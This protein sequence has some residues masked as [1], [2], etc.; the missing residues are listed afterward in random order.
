[1]PTIATRDAAGQ[2]LHVRED[3]VFEHTL[4]TVA[5]PYMLVKDRLDGVEH[6]VQRFVAVARHGERRGALELGA[7]ADEVA[8]DLVLAGIVERRAKEKLAESF[9]LSVL[10]PTAARLAR[11]LDF[12][13]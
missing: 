1:M 9:R 3:V 10:G 8:V 6:A 2:P 4:A 5:A 7:E 11:R 12:L 13:S